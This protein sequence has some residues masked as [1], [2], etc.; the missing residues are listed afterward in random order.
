MAAASAIMLGTDHPGFQCS[1][2]GKFWPF[3]VKSA[4]LLSTSETLGD[5]GPIQKAIKAV[6]PEGRYTQ[7][8][9]VG[10]S[11]NSAMKCDDESGF[12][13]DTLSFGQDALS[14]AG[15]TKGLI[16]ASE[17]IP[18]PMWTECLTRLG[19]NGIFILEATQLDL[20]PFLE[21]MAEDAGGKV[22]DGIQYGTLKLDGKAVGEIRVVRGDVEESCREHHN[23]HQSHSAIEALIAGWPAAEREARR[24]GKP[25]HLSGR[26]WPLWGEAN[27]LKEFPDFHQECWDRGQVIISNVIDPADRR[28]WAIGYFATFPNDDVIQ[29]AEWPP[30][31]YV[32]CRSSPVVNVEDYRDIL[33]QAEAA[34]GK[35]VTNRLIDGLFAAAIKSGRGLNILQMLSAPCLG[36]IEKHGKDGAWVSGRC[37]HRLSYRQA[38]AYNGSV[39]DGHILVATAIGGNGARPKDYTLLDSCPNAIFGQRR[40]SYHENTRDEKGLST[41]VELKFKDFPDLKRMFYLAGLHKWPAEAPPTRLIPRRRR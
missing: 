26:V 1:P 33:L 19:G 17:P 13:M 14:A 30:F 25:L 22:V 7:N 5:T 15:S 11:Y 4:R 23:G 34:I 18:Y 37:P 12:D 8:R 32:A 40:Y 2:F 31:D 36:C 38:P 29:F 9:G 16:L 41:N 28:P 3:P 21:E 24:T 20:A 6:F 27:E 10:K 35:P 39:R